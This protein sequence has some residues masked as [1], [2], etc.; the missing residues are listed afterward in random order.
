MLFALASSFRYEG[1][2]VDMN[3]AKSEAKKLHEAIKDKAKTQE[4]IRIISTRSKLQLNA[5]F[6]QLRDDFSLSV[7]Q[8]LKKE[9]SEDFQDAIQTA[10]KCIRSPSKYFAKILRSSME[11]I[12]TDDEVLTRLVVTRADVDMKDIKAQFMSRTSLSLKSVIAKETRGDY[13][14]FLLALVGE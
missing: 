4:I 1:P 8:V 7:N 12:G 6:N 5:T 2:E 3:L 9:K 11:G 14:D 13:E 10:V